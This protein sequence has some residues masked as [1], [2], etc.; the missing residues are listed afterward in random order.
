V[1]T[2]ETPGGRPCI[3][4]TEACKNRANSRRWY[5]RNRDLDL[6]RRKAAYDP[7]RA[8]EKN[9]LRNYALTAREYASMMES[10]DA[11]CA[12]CGEKAVL[13]IDHDHGTGRVRSLL[14]GSCNLTIGH[15]KEDVG[16]LRAAI[17]YLKKHQIP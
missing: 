15:A 1:R 16:R 10:Q 11:K 3:Y 13:L 6:A 9:L 12:C 5:E 17:R 14:C 4:A 7:E 8:R 2:R